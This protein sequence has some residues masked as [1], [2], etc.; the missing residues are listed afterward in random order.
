MNIT[1]TCASVDGSG[2]PGQN[3][4]THSDFETFSSNVPVNWTLQTGTA[5]THLK[6]TTT[7][8]RGST[9]LEFVG[10]GATLTHVRQTLNSATGTRGRILPDTVYLIAF[11]IRHDGTPPAGGILR[12]SLNDGSS[13]LG[14]NMSKSVTLSGL[15]SS[16]A[17]QTVL[18]TSPI[19]IPSTVY[20]SVELT[21]A[22]TNTRSVYVDEL[23]VTPVPRAAKG[24]PG[25]Y[26]LPGATDWRFGDTATIAVTYSNSGEFNLELD[27]FF[28]FHG[29]GLA[30]PAVGGGAETIADSLIVDP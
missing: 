1:T 22:L 20:V 11:A 17:Y 12:V 2:I 5:P 14:S 7:A 23:V 19:N 18:V 30:L 10:D 29:R 26:A 9:A 15:S 6:S 4:L 13:V 24:G 16:Y 28:D 27:R 3:I 25:I 21:T 8:F